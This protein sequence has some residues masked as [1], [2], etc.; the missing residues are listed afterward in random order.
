[1]HNNFLEYLR[2]ELNKRLKYQSHLENV[3]KI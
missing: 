1:M 3:N 2:A